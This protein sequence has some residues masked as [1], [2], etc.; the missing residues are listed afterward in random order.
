M[1]FEPARLWAPA[2]LWLPVCCPNKCSGPQRHGWKWEFYASPPEVCWHSFYLFIVN[3]GKWS[4]CVSV[5]LARLQDGIYQISASVS[6]VWFHIWEEKAFL[7]WHSSSLCAFCSSIAYWNRSSEV[8]FWVSHSNP[9]GEAPKGL[10]LQSSCMQ[11]LAILYSFQ[12]PEPYFGA[13]I[14]FCSWIWRHC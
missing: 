1:D 3:S 11:P 2:G 10:I 5:L 8:W 13:R 14:T 4:L 7:L 9:Q 12:D 6:C